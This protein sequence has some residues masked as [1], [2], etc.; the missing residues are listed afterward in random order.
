MRRIRFPRLLVFGFTCMV[1]C[2]LSCTEEGGAVVIDKTNRDSLLVDTASAVSGIAKDIVRRADPV[3]GFDYPVGPPNAKNYFKARGFLGMEHLGED[4]NGTGGGNSDFGDYVN[5]VADGVVY[6]VKD[7]GEGWGLVIRMLHNVGTAE[8]PVYIESVYAHVASSW[9]K[10]GN[11]MKRGEVLGTIGT[12]EGKYH[13]HL[14]FEMRGQ[15]GKH[16]SSGYA[17]DTAGF[18]DPSPYIEAH[19]PVQ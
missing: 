14:H 16:I 8:K 18:I 17:G 6:E 15:P 9:V 1:M 3:D 5:A 7:H 2:A 12:A 11:R 19:R 4:W 10:P 13:A